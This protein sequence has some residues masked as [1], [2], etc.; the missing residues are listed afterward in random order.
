[1]N[2]PPHVLPDLAD[3]LATYVESTP[4]ALVFVGPKG[5]PLRGANFGAKVWRPATRAAGLAGVHF[6]DLRGT[7]A[8]L[9]A[10]SGATTAE[11]MRRLGH[12]TPDV[13]MRYQRATD[14]RDAALA[15]LMS[16]AVAAPVVRLRKQ[17]SGGANSAAT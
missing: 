16:E 1:M 17:G 5:G 7:A 12:A 14:D 13:A 10:V 9:A 2:L 3:H 15:Q 8:T 11:L 6:H 4:D